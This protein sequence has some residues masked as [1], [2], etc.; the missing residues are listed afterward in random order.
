MSTLFFYGTL[1]HIPLLEI[2][3]GRPL[4][5]DDMQDGRAEGYSVCAVK[6]ADFP[7]I[8][9]G[10]KGAEGIIVRGLS[11]VEVERLNYYEGGF[12]YALTPIEITTDTG[13]ETARVYFPVPGQ[14]VTDGVWN[15][16]TWQDRWSDLVCLTATE[17]MSFFG[18]KSHTELDFMF[19]MMRARAAAKLAARSEHYGF[20]PGGFTREDAQTHQITTRHTGFFALEEHKISHKTYG[21]GE[22]SDIQREVFLG[23]DAAILLPYDPVRDRVLLVEQFRAGPWVRNDNAPWMLEPVA[24]RID[25]GETAEEAAHR[26]AHEEANLTLRKLHPVAK[27]YASPACN[28]EFFHIFVGETDLP[29]E[30]AGVAGLASEAEDIRSYL[31]SFEELMSMVDS[32]GAANAPLVLAALWLARRRDALRAAT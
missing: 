9:F 14:L 8:V 7:V 16:G 24:G 29:D 10:G 18:K 32:F 17:A 4:A 30:I 11:E 1:R 23:S 19:P 20:S 6:D 31:F 21:G 15:F 22:I 5:Q 27:V 28:T 12:D 3:L 13:M 2:V 25:A 26:E